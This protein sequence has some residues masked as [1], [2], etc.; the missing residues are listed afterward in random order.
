MAIFHSY[1]S[2]PEGKWNSNLCKMLLWPQPVPPPMVFWHNIHQYPNSSRAAESPKRI[3]ARF[4][5]FV[6]Q[7]GIDVSINCPPIV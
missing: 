7:G 6:T 2:L 1:V 4:I 5:G 3:T